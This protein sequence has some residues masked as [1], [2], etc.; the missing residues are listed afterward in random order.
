MRP[1]FSMPEADTILIIGSSGQIGT[2]LTEKLQQVYGEKKVIASDIKK[3]NDYEG[4]FEQL[5]VL[6]EKRLNEIVGKHHI[7]QVYHLAAM[8]SA[9]AEKNPRLAWKLNMDGLLNVLELGKAKKVKKIFW[10]SS[11]AIFGPTTP[12]KNVPQFTTMEPTTIYGISKL[13]GERWCEYYFQKYGTDVRSV[14]Y[15]GLISYKTPPGGGTTDYAVEIFHHALEKNSYEC[16]LSA[17]TTLP[18]M[19][20]PD[21][22]RSTME[23]MEAES[24][25]IKIRSS[26]N[27][28]AINFSPKEIFAEIKNH[29]KEFHISYKPDFRQ[30]IAADWPNS[31]DDSSARKDWNWSPQCDLKMMVKDMLNN[32][33]KKYSLK[34]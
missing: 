25:E 26:Y 18:M 3:T 1:S 16:F 2:E 22:I 24:S 6:N 12:K 31:I 17:D 29:I 23:L 34:I 28:S 8:L 7:T 9:T 15:P 30:Q 4:I 19:Y 27:I 33:S 20:M 10:P 5:D 13:A 32:L 14:R 11:I 21:A